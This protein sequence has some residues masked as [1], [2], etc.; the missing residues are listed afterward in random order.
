MDMPHNVKI[1][2]GRKLCLAVLL[3]D[4]YEKKLLNVYTST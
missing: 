4:V 2:D 1:T 3:H